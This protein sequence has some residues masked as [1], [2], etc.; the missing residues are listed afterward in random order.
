MV[1]EL[2]YRL[3]ERR[4]A[5]QLAGAALPRHIALILDGNR[6]FARKKG[7]Q[8]V[9]EGHRLGADRIHDLLDWC[10]ERDI[11]HV[12]L[13]LLSTENLSRDDEEVRDL[14]SIIGDTV[15]RVA[16]TRP[17]VRI[18][19]LGA[20]DVLPDDLHRTLKDAVGLTSDGEG[21]HVQVA[22][23]YS[24]R[25]E[26][27]DALRSMLVSHME[28][29]ADIAEVIDSL[30]P[31][32]IS[33]HLYTTGTPDPDLII[34]TSGEIRLSGFLLWQSVHSEFHFCDAYWP[35]FRRIDFLRALRDFASRQRRYGR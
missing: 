18:T 20:L 25:E 21:L 10:S 33:D 4:L 16:R 29:G 5:A 17:E 6:R 7:F 23:G 3:Y 14:A 22:V 2:A 35:A 24:G 26:I 11:A 8:S 27:T 30:S 15:M 31:E 28:A 34:R 9:A 13:W 32:A 1:R 12:T 19:T